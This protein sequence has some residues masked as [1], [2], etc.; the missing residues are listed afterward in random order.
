MERLK[1]DDNIGL[2]VCVIRNG[3]LSSSL[4]AVHS[5]FIGFRAAA[6]TDEPKQFLRVFLLLEFRT[7]MENSQRIRIGWHARV[8]S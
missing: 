1:V 4:K 2:V 6:T 8:C 5:H 3:S 7:A